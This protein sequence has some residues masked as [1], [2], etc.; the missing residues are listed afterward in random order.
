[1]NSDLTTEVFLSI[2]YAHIHSIVVSIYI[3]EQ[4]ICVHYKII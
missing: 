3:N 2:Y 4:Y 1:M